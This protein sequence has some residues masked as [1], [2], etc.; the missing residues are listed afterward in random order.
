MFVGGGPTDFGPGTFTGADEGFYDAIGVVEYPPLGTIILVPQGYVS[1]ASFLSEATFYGTFADLGLT[2]GLSHVWSWGSPPETLTLEVDCVVD[3]LVAHWAFDGNADDATP[4]QFDGVV[5]GAALA[6]GHDG[7]P[8][9]AFSFTDPGDAIDFGPY[10]TLA[11]ARGFPVTLAA[12]VR[13]SCPPTDFCTIYDNEII[14]GVCT[15]SRS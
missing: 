2:P 11:L 12:W 5:S 13:H 15:T 14:P 3:G 1:N 10:T 7:T 4:C 9:G 8:G 6:T